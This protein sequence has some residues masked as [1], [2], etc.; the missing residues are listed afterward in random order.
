MMS[1]HL[2]VTDLVFNN[3][4][5]GDNLSL[6]LLSI[7]HKFAMLNQHGVNDQNNNLNQLK[8]TLLSKVGMVQEV[9]L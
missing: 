1:Y 5:I 4:K 7:V 3:L 2:T 8:N 9:L 6:Q